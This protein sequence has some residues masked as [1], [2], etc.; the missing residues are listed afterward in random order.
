M[1][2]QA[3]G[4]ILHRP[5]EQP[6][7]AGAAATVEA[8]RRLAADRLGYDPRPHLP[9]AGD[10]LLAATVEPADLP[11][12][13]AFAVLLSRALPGVWLVL[14]RLYLRDGGFFRRRRGRELVLVP[15][16]DVHLPRG[17]RTAIGSPRVRGQRGAG[18]EGKSP[19]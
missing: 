13:M 16:N 15:A 4:A 18:P 6:W 17:L 5:A 7:P 9:P 11:R 14:G 2:P 19:G 10:Y 1:K 8:V 3:R 12:A